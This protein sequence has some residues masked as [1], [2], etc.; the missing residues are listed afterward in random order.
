MKKIS[1]IIV[2]LLTILT[3]QA[4]LINPTTG[5]GTCSK[6]RYVQISGTDFYYTGASLDSVRFFITTNGNGIV[7]A[8]NPVL[9]DT[10][11]LITSATFD[12]YIKLL[13]SP[14]NVFL[15]EWTRS[16]THGSYTPQYSNFGSNGDITTESGYGTIVSTCVLAPVTL[17]NVSAQLNNGI[18]TFKWTSTIESN[19]AYYSIE[20]SADGL[21]WLSVGQLNS[22]WPQGTGT[23]PHTYAFT[24]NDLTMI[25]AGVELGIF[26][27]LLFAGASLYFVPKLFIKYEKYFMLLALSLTILVTS[28]HKTNTVTTKET[29]RYSYFRLTQTDL[30]GTVTYYQTIFKVN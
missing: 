11:F 7:S 9:W 29:V 30:D 5:S 25:E 2:L 3:S 18:L 26:I 15:E 20:G 13:S 14:E 1:L 12:L 4:H 10:A 8:T 6:K 22:V 24:Y 28:C 21:T 19:N 17:T 27:Y 16:S 23:T